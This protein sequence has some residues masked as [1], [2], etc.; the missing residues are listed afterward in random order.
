MKKTTLL[1]FLFVLLIAVEVFSQSS[2]TYDF[3]FQSTWNA[4]EHSSIPSGA[5]W[6]DLVGATHNTTNEFVQLGENATL[7]IKNVAEF[8][9]N[10][11]FEN[12]V[13]LAITDEKAD[14][15]LQQGFAP[16]AAISSAALVDIEVTEDFPLVTLVSMVAPSPDWF[17]AVNSLNLRNESN[18]DWRDTFTIDVFTYDAGT[19]N[20]TNYSSPNSANSP[21]PVSM[22]NGFPINGFK[23]GTLTVTLK[24]VLSVETPEFSNVIKLYPNP[25]NGLIAIN[26]NTSRILSSIRVYDILGN[27]VKVILLKTNTIRNTIDLTNL[28]NGIYLARI[29]SVDGQVKTQK[30]II[31]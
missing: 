15:W 28:T 8:G 2:A 14:Q 21:V 10:S 25:S 19:D 9:D 6:S 16:F 13:N 18:D 26:N 31:K 20:G 4:A 7:G 5:H 29:A 17:I 12:E 27:Q 3:T 1:L 22:I 11:A 30:L 23:M 24:S